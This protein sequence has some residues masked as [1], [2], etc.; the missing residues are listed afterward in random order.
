MPVTGAW[1]LDAGA[2]WEFQASLGYKTSCIVENG[3]SEPVSGTHGSEGR[4]NT[5]W[6]LH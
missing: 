4:A 1:E 2:H 5:P 3:L 6:T